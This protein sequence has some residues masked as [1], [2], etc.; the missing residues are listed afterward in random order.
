MSEPI[1]KTAWRRNDP[2]LEADAKDYWARNALVPAEH[3]DGR[4][5]ELVA[6]GYRD[7]KVV[8]VT[9][10]ELVM[11][12]GLRARF[13][14][15]RVSVDPDERRGTLGARLGGYMRRTIEAWSLENPQEDVK[16]FGGIITAAEFGEKQRQPVWN[17][18]GVDIAVAGY[19]PS[20][21]QLRIGWFAHARV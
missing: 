15:G 5:K 18:W 8:A 13:A 2:Q 7:G 19:L 17:D 21:E 10:A 1:I 9:T 14:M 16:G 20:G 12:P 3:R 4:A 6:V 11:L